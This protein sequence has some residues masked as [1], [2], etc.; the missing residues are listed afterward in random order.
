VL[1]PWWAL[2]LNIARW[3]DMLPR[4]E[5]TTLQPAGW[6]QRLANLVL[7]GLLIYG[8]SRFVPQVPR[9]LLGKIAIGP[10]T[11]YG[12]GLVDRLLLVFLFA[13]QEAMSGRTLGKF[14]TRTRVVRLDGTR[15]TLW[16][17]V[18]RSFAR[19]I[20]FD[21]FSA[22]NEVPRPWHDSLSGTMVVNDRSKPAERKS[23]VQPAIKG[24]SR[25]SIG[26]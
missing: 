15:P 25:K 1:V 14:I 20:P 16:Q 11:I 13:A 8:A 22:L 5:S 21:A 4:I 24:S 26:E 23:V 17:I 9:E 19:F 3:A 12:S 2:Q 6:K 7:D 18:G 10:L